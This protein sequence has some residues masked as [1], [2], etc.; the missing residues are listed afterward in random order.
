VHAARRSRS[1]GALNALRQ[2]KTENV[3]ATIRMRKHS[4]TPRFQMTMN[5]AAPIARRW[6]M[7]I[8][9]TCSPAEYPRRR[10]FRR[11]Y[12]HGT[13]AH[14]AMSSVSANAIE[15]PPRRD[16]QTLFTT[17]A[18]ERLRKQRKI[19]SP[20]RSCMQG[21][22]DYLSNNLSVSSGSVTRTTS[23]SL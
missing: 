17:I 23:S 4:G 13:S 8:S 15:G 10:A 18:R 14:A 16:T 7:M 21:E 1:A 22:K 5:S 6:Q 12:G 11:F 19:V 2:S 9:G 3:G 20:C